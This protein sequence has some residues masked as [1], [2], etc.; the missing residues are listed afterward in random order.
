MGYVSQLGIYPHVLVPSSHGRNPQYGVS[1]DI[2]RQNLVAVYVAP[3]L[4]SQL[5][6]D[7]SA[8]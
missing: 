3:P 8:L 5:S 6:V 7:R 1:S 2:L 4:I